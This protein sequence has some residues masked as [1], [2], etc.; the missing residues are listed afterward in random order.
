MY[1][2]DGTT[3]GPYINCGFRPALLWVKNTSSGSTDWVILDTTTSVVNP[4][5][6]RFAA[7]QQ[8]AQVSDSS[9]S[10]QFDFYSNGFKSVGGDGTFVNTSGD[11]YIYCA[12]AE[13]PT[14]NLYGAQ[15]N[16]K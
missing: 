16:A 5:F 7:N 10:A 11:N 13:T 15:A 6:R 14:N 8:T 1:T 12:W 2:G 3:D 9:T 4:M